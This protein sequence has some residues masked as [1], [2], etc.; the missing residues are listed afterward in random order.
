MEFY[1]RRNRWH[2]IQRYFPERLPRQTSRFFTY[3]VQKL[4]FRLRW[5]RIRMEWLAYRDFKA[6]RMGR[7]SRTF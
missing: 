5:D 3:Q 7:T 1:C 4:A 2:F 6:G